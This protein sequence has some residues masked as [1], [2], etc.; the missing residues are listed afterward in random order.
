MHTG[1]EDY[2]VLDPVARA[3]K[4]LPVRFFLRVHA[5]RVLTADGAPLALAE[6]VMDYDPRHA[7]AIHG[8]PEN[9]VRDIRRRPRQARRRAEATGRDRSVGR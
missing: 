9:D 3:P 6:A 4:V 2:D 7:G 1:V 8:R 5:R